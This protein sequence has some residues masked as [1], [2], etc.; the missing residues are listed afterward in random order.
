MP[1]IG[2]WGHIDHRH[3]VADLAPL[4][5]GVEDQREFV[6]R[7]IAGRALRGANYDRLGILAETVESFGG[8]G[9]MIGAANRLGKPLRPQPLNFVEGKIGACRDHQIIVRQ[10]SAVVEFDPVLL[11]VDPLGT[12]RGKADALLGR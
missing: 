11:R 5:F 2:F 7:A 4:Q 12:D 1:D 6:S 9:C 10:R 3:L 8:V